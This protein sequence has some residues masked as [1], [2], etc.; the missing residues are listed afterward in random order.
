MS[1]PFKDP[2]AKK[3]LDWMPASKSDLDAMETRLTNL[4]VTAVTG[5]EKH[6]IE[7]LTAKLKAAA[8]TLQSAVD[9]NK[10]T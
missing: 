7:E 8:D 4:I 10:Q 1:N 2:D 3:F 9:K 5:G 6:R